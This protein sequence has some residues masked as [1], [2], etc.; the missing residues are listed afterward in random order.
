MAKIKLELQEKSYKDEEI[1]AALIRVIGEAIQKRI[2]LIEI[3]PNAENRH[4]K[5][6]VLRL[7]AKPSMKCL[8]YKVERDADNY[9]RIFVHFRHKNDK[10]Y[11]T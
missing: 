6:N 11:H 10:G 8:Y 4:I 3:I 2:P 1:E 5:K 9:G 7:L